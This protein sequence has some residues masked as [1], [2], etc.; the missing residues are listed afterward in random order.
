MLNNFFKKLKNIF[1]A[2]RAKLLSP[3]WRVWYW[4]I[5]GLDKGGEVTFLNYGY[6]G[7]NK[8]TLNKE[9]ENNRQSIGL[10]DHVAG[11]VNLEGF[12]VLE[13]GCGRGGG[14]SYVAR[15][16]SP[17]S[18]KGMDLCKK[19]INFCR[20]HY[21]IENLSFCWGDALNLPF[22]DKSFN[23][24]VNVESSHR[25]SDMER[26]LGEV[27]R[28]LKTGGYF[29]FADLRDAELIEAMRKRLNSCRLK[30][31]KE[32]E[33]T[34]NVAKAMLLDSRKK[35]NLIERLVPKFLHGLSR[36]FAGTKKT[37]LYKSFMNG[38]KKYLHYILQ[39]D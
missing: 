26:F 15:Y 2:Y 8:L 24:V 17:K 9:D 34:A 32:E 36:E 14:A 30:V 39:K 23:A 31:I 33:I 20:K 22:A 28:V 5:A 21:D 12:D 3:F 11:A 7:G 37:G 13:V 16:L 6:A 35:T 1:I 27:Y 25:Y 10:Y 18:V 4:Y 29:L 19:S 38:K